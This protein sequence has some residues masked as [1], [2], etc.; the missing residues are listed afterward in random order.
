MTRP[1]FETYWL[2]NG[3]QYFDVSEVCSLVIENN[4]VAVEVTAEAQLEQ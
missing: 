3:E 1:V 2:V 4:V